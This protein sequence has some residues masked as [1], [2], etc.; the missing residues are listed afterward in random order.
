MDE[1]EQLHQGRMDP[2]MG[3]WR[4]DGRLRAG[5]CRWTFLDDGEREWPWRHGGRGRVEQEGSV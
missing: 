5:G 2:Q 1:N 4:A 3:T